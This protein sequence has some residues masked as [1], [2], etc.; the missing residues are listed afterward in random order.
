MNS[1]MHIWATSITFK[2]EMTSFLKDTQLAMK[3]AKLIDSFPE[4]GWAIFQDN[5]SAKGEKAR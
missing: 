5:A 2:S 4:L 3:Q 1:Q